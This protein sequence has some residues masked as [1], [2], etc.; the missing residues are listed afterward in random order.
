MI[1]R[2]DAGGDP[3]PVGRLQRQA[4]VEND[5]GR[6][7]GA[8]MKRLL[9]PQDFVRRARERVELPARERRRHT[10]GACGGRPI[11][12]R[13]DAAVRTILRPELIEP[14]DRGDSMLEAQQE[15]LARIRHGTATDRHDEI[16]VGLQRPLRCLHNVGLRPV[17]PYACLL[18]TSPSPRD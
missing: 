18:Y 10:H 4:G 2:P 11:V 1:D 17:R 6:N 5:A 13:Q 3:Q 7:Q 16:G 9:A 8:M 15:N 14:L 12:R